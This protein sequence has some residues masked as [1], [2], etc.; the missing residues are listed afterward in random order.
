MAIEII[1]P[2]DAVEYVKKRKEL[3]DRQVVARFEMQKL[4]REIEGI[5]KELNQMDRDLRSEMK[6]T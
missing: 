1:D 3:L 2:V 4:K 5:E 6:F